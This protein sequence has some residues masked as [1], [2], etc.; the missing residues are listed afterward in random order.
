MPTDLPPWIK[1][2][3]EVA[4]VNAKRDWYWPV[5]ITTIGAKYISTEEEMHSGSSVKDRYSRE[6]LKR[7]VAGFYTPDPRTLMSMDNP[8]VQKIAAKK[9]R[10]ETK[11]AMGPLLHQWN[12]SG[13]PEILRKMIGL[14]Q[15]H[16]DDSRPDDVPADEKS[17]VIDLQA[18][19]LVAI[20]AGPR[21]EQ[22]RRIRVHHASRVDADTWVVTGADSAGRAFREH[23][24]TGTEVTFLGRWTPGAT[25]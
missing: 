15:D 8:I 11:N 13:D 4:A 1:R 17:R 2:G 24:P 16:L 21:R 7:S 3:A 10:G 12:E 19:D 18:D 6:T 20:P 5:R 23:L 22:A 14:L 25:W 9:Q